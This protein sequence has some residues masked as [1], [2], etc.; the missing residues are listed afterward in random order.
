VPSPCP[1]PP[2]DPIYR[3]TKTKTQKTQNNNEMIDDVYNIYFEKH[4]HKNKETFGGVCN[5]LFSTQTT[6]T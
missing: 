5:I 4:Q 1:N 3:Q 2:P 6:T